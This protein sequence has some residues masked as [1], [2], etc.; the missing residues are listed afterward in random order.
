M[1]TKNKN[2]HRAQPMSNWP[3]K[4]AL[5]DQKRREQDE[6]WERDRQ[7]ESAAERE[8]NADIYQRILEVSLVKDPVAR[9]CLIFILEKLKT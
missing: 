6:K 4:S 8:R 7:A 5:R 1:I 2:W 9:D 3:S